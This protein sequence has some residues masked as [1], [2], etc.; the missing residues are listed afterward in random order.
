[1]RTTVSIEDEA[2]EDLLRL[3]GEANRT[4]AVQVA[5]EFYN[6]RK[7]LEQLLALRGTL[8]IVGTEALDQADLAEQK[9]LER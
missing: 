5:V 3:S 6:R 7:K 2:F 4:R 8:D 1:M 9:R